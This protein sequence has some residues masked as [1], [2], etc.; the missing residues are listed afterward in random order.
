[1]AAEIRRVRCAPWS[2]ANND[3]GEWFT[4]EDQEDCV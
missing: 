2:E 4:H 1:M 3:R